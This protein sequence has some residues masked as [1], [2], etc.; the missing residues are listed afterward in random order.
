V[1]ADTAGSTY[2]T[3][4]YLVDAAGAVVSGACNDD[5]GC[6]TGGFTSELQSRLARLL[7]AGS[8]AIAVS[9]SSA[10]DRGAFTLR[11][12]SIPTNYG[13]FFYDA[14]IAGSMTVSDRL[15]G[16]SARAPL[17]ERGDSG[18]DVRWFVSCGGAAS[19]LF[20]VCRSDGG[21]FVRAIGASL[22]DPVLYVYSGLTGAQVQCNDDGGDAYN[23]RGTGGDTQ[24]YGSRISAPMPRGISALVVDE[25]LTR[26]GMNYTL[27]Y[28]AERP[29]SRWCS[30]ARAPSV[31]P[32][33]LRELHT[34]H[35]AVR[36]LVTAATA[37]LRAAAADPRLGALATPARG[38][39][40][41]RWIETPTRPPP[42]DV[43]SSSLVSQAG[44]F[45]T[46]VARLLAMGERGFDLD[47]LGPSATAATGHSQGVMA[48]LLF[49]EGRGFP[50]SSWRRAAEFASY[51]FWQGYRMQESF[52]LADGAARGARRGRA[53][54]R[55]RPVAHGRG[56][57]PHRRAPV[58][59]ARALSRGQPAA[60]AHRCV[61]R[62]RLHPQGALGPAR[63]ARGLRARPRGLPHRGA[64][65]PSRRAASVGARSSLPGSSSPPRR[66]STRATWRPGAAPCRR[67][68]ARGHQFRRRPLRLPVLGNDGTDLRTAADD[69]ALTAALLRMQ[70][71]EPVR[72]G[73]VCAALRGATPRA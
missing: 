23:C 48:A 6:T 71:V 63:V 68:R 4:I 39:D 9:G 59:G 14:P 21:S 38:F 28:E 10:T 24:N 19:S 2:N 62:Q 26:N 17:C 11:V 1:Y 42:P 18:E 66:P 61:P 36:T 44:I 8:Y 5:S 41:A 35:L 51:F 30:A 47:A 45:L 72:W 22:Y 20:S 16:T 33:E 53:G 70:H 69:A 52:V 32:R 3:K 55:R 43:L 31:A 37:R 64:R 65:R 46:S 58:R 50:S 40:L 49:A 13:N 57:G 67:P 15:V 27:H 12:Q 25:R 54:R 34:A 7:A 73:A 56:G 29:A 60:P